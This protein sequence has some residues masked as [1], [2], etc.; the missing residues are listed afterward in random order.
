MV[1]VGFYTVPDAARLLRIPARNINRWL[2]GYQYQRGDTRHQL[3]PLWM[4]Q[5]PA[6]G[7][8]IEFGFRDLIAL[9]FV[10][11]FLDAGLGPQTIRRCIAYARNC[12][13]D[14]HPFSTRGLQTDGKT[15]F[16]ASATGHEDEKVPDLKSNRF[17][18]KTVIERTF[19][20]L[21]KCGGAER[22]RTADLLN[23]IQ[24]LS[25]LSYS[26][27]VSPGKPA[28]DAGS[29]AGDGRRDIDPTGSLIKG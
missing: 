4:A 18:I 20:D 1:G 6:D 23:A 21:W 15:I 29:R 3:P 16:L 5:L 8:H 19:K 2:H 14:A 22:D 27:I 11:A 28:L 10:S 25:Q 7:R 12:V 9:R 13:E 24:A 26:P 17:Q